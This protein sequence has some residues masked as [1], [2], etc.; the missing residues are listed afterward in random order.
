[1]PTFV[2][3]GYNPIFFAR[4]VFGVA[5]ILG[6]GNIAFL[7]VLEQSYLAPFCLTFGLNIYLHILEL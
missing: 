3:F 6:N 4:F 1:M 5:K 2:F 7:L